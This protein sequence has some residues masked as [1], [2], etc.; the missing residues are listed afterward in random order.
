[1]FFAFFFAFTRSRYEEITNEN[2]NSIIGGSSPT[3]IKFYLTDCH[4]CQELRP[5]F[6]EASDMFPDVIFGGVNCD[7]FKSICEKHKVDGYPRLLYFAPHKREGIRYADERKANVIADF[8]EEKTNIKAHRPPKALINVDPNSIDTFKIQSECVFLS[9]CDPNENKCKRFT[10]QLQQAAVAFQLEDHISIGSV[11]CR[12]YPDLCTAGNIHEIPTNLFYLNGT[13]YK[14]D[15]PNNLRGIINFINEKCGTERD[16]DG[17]LNDTAGLIPEANEIVK[18]FLSSPDKIS[19]I[20]QMKQ[21]EGAEFYVKVMERYILQGI[22]QVH[23]DLKKM[24]HMLDEK[25]GSKKAIDQMKKR[26]NI[27]LLFVPR[28]DEEEL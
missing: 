22:E 5:E 14:Y 13:S 4:Y 17:L 27:F 2:E 24:G 3:L 10:P 20:E 25:K 18:E 9:F 12:K 1:M 21:I 6:L 28:F 15:N 26:Y 16:L 7:D 19:K 23:K 8:I 11:N